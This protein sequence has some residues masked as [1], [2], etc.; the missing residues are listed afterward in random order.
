MITCVMRDPSVCMCVFVHAHENPSKSGTPQFNNLSNLLTFP[1]YVA[2][3]RRGA[4][5]ESKSIYTY[6]DIYIRLL[7]TPSNPS[8]PKQSRR[9]DTWNFEF[10][11][12]HTSGEGGGGY[13]G[14]HDF[15][16]YNNRR[17]YATFSSHT[18]NNNY[19]KASHL[20]VFLAEV[21]L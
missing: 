4:R 13:V 6:V 21:I 1:R 15:F 17:Y 19:T 8:T 10:G 7:F 14:L 16:I 9:M 12:T 11:I 3:L 18:Q 5:A 20:L 2:Q